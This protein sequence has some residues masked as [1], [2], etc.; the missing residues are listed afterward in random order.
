MQYR[1]WGAD[2]AAAGCAFRGV[3]GGLG[4][5]GDPDDYRLSG[6]QIELWSRKCNTGFGIQFILLSMLSEEVVGPIVSS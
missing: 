4:L 2:N 3:G 5:P 1:A 6:K